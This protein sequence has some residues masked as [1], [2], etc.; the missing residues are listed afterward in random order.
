MRA[1]SP[2]WCATTCELS[3]TSQKQDIGDPQVINAFARK[4]GDETHLD[5]LYV[6]TCADVRGTNPKLWNSWKASLFRDFYQRVKR[7]LRRGLES[8]IDA[9][10]LVRETQDAA[11]RLLLERGIAEEDIVRAWT[12]FTPGLLPAALPGGDRLAHAPA[13]RARCDLG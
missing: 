2:G 7:A 11:R 4:V 8:P 3:I 6:L 1:W 13:R 10:H 5:Y 9:E 12:R